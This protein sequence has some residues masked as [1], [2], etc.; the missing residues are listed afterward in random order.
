VGAPLGFSMSTQSVVEVSPVRSSSRRALDADLIHKTLAGDPAAGRDL[1]RHY[2]PVAIS[3]LRKLG[4]RPDE[5]EDA[6]QEVFLQFFRH[7]ASFRGEAELK[8]WLFRLCITEARRVRRRRKVGASLAALLRREPPSDA[9][10]PAS[11]SD[12][13]IQELVKRAL[14]RM[15]PEQ[16]RAFILFEV[17]GLTGKEVAEIAG[18]SLPSTF[19]R[20][21]EAQRVFQ[22]TLDLR[23]D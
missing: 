9:V 22:E 4:T 13:T 17:E 5:I 14:D 2:L 18:R 19:R 7:L 8:T 1:H 10:P 3:F 12:A 15:E 11:R 20:L 23:A 6:C 21:Y 16:R